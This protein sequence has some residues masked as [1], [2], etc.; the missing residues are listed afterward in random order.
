M[1]SQS[2]ID[3]IEL[4]HIQSVAAPVKEQL[5]TGRYDDA[6]I[7]F[8]RTANL[9]LEYS[10]GI[11]FYNFLVFHALDSS[12]DKRTLLA[13]G[14]YQTNASFLF[15]LH[16]SRL[17]PTVIFQYQSCST[18]AFRIAGNSRTSFKHPAKISLDRMHFYDA[19]VNAGEVTS[20]VINV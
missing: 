3:G 1:L 6:L 14:K 10:N 11:D 16:R 15:R 8:Q 12:T 4:R 20:L 5:E 13:N 2:V 7:S 18:C 19:A 9:V 17:I